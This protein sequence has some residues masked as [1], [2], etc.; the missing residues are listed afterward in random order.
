MPQKKRQISSITPSFHSINHFNISLLNALDVMENLLT[1]SCLLL[2]SRGQILLDQPGDRP[3]SKPPQPQFDSVLCPIWTPTWQGAASGPSGVKV[4]VERPHWMAPLA[5][6][7]STN[8]S[9]DDAT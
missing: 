7:A 9:C 3:S 4:W 2:A 6:N 8:D 5:N 1:L